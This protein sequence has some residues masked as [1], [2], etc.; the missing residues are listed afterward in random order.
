MTKSDDLTA[1]MAGLAIEKVLRNIGQPVHEK[2]STMLQGR[3]ATFADCYRHPELLRTILTQIFGDSY[4]SVMTQFKME[5][6]NIEE[7]RV[8]KFIDAIG[9]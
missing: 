1:D 2:A 8:A 7:R 3:Y 9:R 4:V 5:L 6:S